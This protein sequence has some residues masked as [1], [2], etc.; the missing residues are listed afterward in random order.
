MRVVDSKRKVHSTS[1]VRVVDASVMPVE[2]TG[3]TTSPLYA[4]AE[5]A[6]DIVKNNSWFSRSKASIFGTQAS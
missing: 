4:V 1:H 6:G 5:K 2:L 3:H